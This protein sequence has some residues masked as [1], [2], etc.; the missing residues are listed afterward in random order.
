MMM[1]GVFNSNVSGGPLFDGDAS[2]IASA[3]MDTLIPLET[4]STQLADDTLERL[5]ASK[6][7]ARCQAAFNEQLCQRVI[8]TMTAL[9]AHEDAS[10]EMISALCKVVINLILQYPPGLAAVHDT[11]VGGRSIPR[12]VS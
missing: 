4:D 1:E 7:C 3:V 5:E 6:I 11:Q 12:K 9:L 2:R 8:A 10:S